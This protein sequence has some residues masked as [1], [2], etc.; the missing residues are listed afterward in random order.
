LSTASD[1]GFHRGSGAKRLWVEAAQLV[2]V[3]MIGEI[4][5]QF[6]CGKEMK[7]EDYMAPVRQLDLAP[8]TAIIVL[9]TTRFLNRID[10]N[11]RS[12]AD[13]AHGCYKV[14][15]QRDDTSP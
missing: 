14:P 11:S 10:G 8:V 15:E 1:A 13:R 4:A 5:P 12:A 9:E 7:V 3:E 2:D 6:G